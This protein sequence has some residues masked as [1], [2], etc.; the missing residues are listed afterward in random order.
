MNNPPTV[1]RLALAGATVTGGISAILG[2]VW[3]LRPDWGFFYADPDLIPMVGLAGTTAATVLHT[4]MAVVG[5]IAA[6][7]AL[8]GKLG[9][10][11]IVL[12]GSAQLV[13]FGIALSSMATLSV[14]GYLVAMGMPVFGVVLLVQLIRRYPVARWAV[15]AP[16][17][18]AAIVG[19][20]LGW[21]T[22]GMVVSTLG[23]GLADS[24]GVLGIVLLALLL[25]F[26][27]TV[28]IVSAS[29]GTVGAARATAWVTRHR[30]V[31]TV[32][33]ALGPMPY[34]LVRLTWLTPWTAHIPGEALTMDVRVWGLTLSTGAWVGFVLTL[35]LIRPWGTVWPRWMPWVA[36][37][38]VPVAAAAVPGGVI[39]AVVCFTAVPILYTA[40]GRGVASLVES[41]ITFPCW[42][43][44]PALALAV[45]GYVGH[46]RELAVA[47]DASATAVHA[48]V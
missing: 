35:G 37:R 36:G 21:N 47:E 15:G 38:P 19:I 2:T 20:V 7:A 13:V 44:G 12:I 9:R 34:A 41:A 33:A 46:R 11:G 4:V 28:A 27:W 17:L 8:S 48:G 40:A 31:I 25:G 5:A 22:I 42:F 43:W 32:I 45:W 14:A 39:A 6:V 30:K 3:L 16:L 26:S 23:S 18:V 24:M 29:R 10:T 1:N